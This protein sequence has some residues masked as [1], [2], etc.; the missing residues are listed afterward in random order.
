MNTGDFSDQSPRTLT[1]RDGQHS[2]LRVEREF[3]NRNPWAAGFAQPL[4]CLRIP[5]AHLRLVATR[6]DLPIGSNRDRE[7][8][9]FHA[10]ERQAALTSCRVDES[11]GAVVETVRTSP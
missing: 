10:A 2:F 7:H 3:V 5:P 11:P 6:C 1:T 9:L 4:G 8:L